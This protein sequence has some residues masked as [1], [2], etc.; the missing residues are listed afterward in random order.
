MKSI[1]ISLDI[2]PLF[3]HLVSKLVQAPVITYDEIFQALVAE[4]DFLLPKPF[5]DPTPPPPMYSLFGFS[6]VWQTEETSLRPVI[7]I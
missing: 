1:Q 5:L 3:F 2:S 7:S 6:R 4:G